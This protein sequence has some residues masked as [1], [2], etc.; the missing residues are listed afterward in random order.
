IALIPL[1]GS[2]L[3]VAHRFEWSEM[4]L[5]GLIA[6][7]GTCASRGDSGAPLW[8]V[9]LLFSTY[10]ILFEGFDLLRAS[11]RPAYSPWESAIFPLNAFAFISLSYLKWNADAPR[12]L[13]ALAAA[14]GAAYLISTILRARLRPPSSFDADMTTLGRALSGGYEG[15]ISLT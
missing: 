11:R 12:Y 14:I 3:Y 2:L 13:H 6:T 1:A 4:A 8:S 15:P 10:W 9:Q 7:Y 5:F